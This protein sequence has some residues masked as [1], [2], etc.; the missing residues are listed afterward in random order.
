MKKIVI[1]EFM[2]EKAVDSIR[3]THKIVY[4]PTLVD[5]MDE[6][7]VELKD[8][9]GLIVRNR[10]LVTAELLDKSPQVKVVGRLGVGLDNISLDE[11]AKRDIK[12]FPATGC[13]DQSVAEYVMCCA[14]MLIRKAYLSSSLTASGSWPRSEMIGCELAG[15]TFGFVGWGAIARET[16]SRVRAFG[17]PMIGYD[18]FIEVD[19]KRWQDCKPVSLDELFKQSDIISLHVPLNK[20]TK[21]LVNSDTIAMMKKS[22]VLI[23]AARGGVVDEPALIEA[24]RAGSIQGAALDVFAQEP[25]VDE[26]SKIF[27]DVENLI[28]TPHIAGVTAESNVRV[29]AMIARVVSEAL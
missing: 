7:L 17:C 13:N 24:L 6:L 12:V 1:S 22:A 20:E 9:D 27:K 8:A 15:K 23:N 3:D 26:K 10:T 19:D 25:I 18:P 2:D 29:S 16:A 4:S 14:M 11:C 28:L 5:R 21:N